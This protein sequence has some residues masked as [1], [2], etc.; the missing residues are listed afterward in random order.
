MNRPPLPFA[1]PC[2]EPH[3]LPHRWWTLPTATLKAL[4]RLMVWPSAMPVAQAGAAME[5][6]VLHHPSLVARAMAQGLRPWEWVRRFDDRG[7]L[8]PQGS[9]GPTTSLLYLLIVHGDA[10]SLSLALRNRMVLTGD[11]HQTW[12]S[13][14]LAVL[15]ASRHAAVGTLVGRLTP[16]QRWAREAALLRVLQDHRRDA[17]LPTTGEPVDQDDLMALLDHPDRRR[18]T[19]A[20]SEPL[21]V[22]AVR[23]DVSDG[24]LQA[25]RDHG[26]VTN[27]A[28]V[29]ALRELM[30]RGNPVQTER[31]L[32]WGLALSQGPGDDLAALD[33]INRTL[34]GPDEDEASCL[35]RE[36]A[37]LDTLACHGWVPGPRFRQEAVLAAARAGAPGA[38]LPALIA[39]GANPRAH[40]GDGNTALHRVFRPESHQ[41]LVQALLDLGVDPVHPNAQGDSPLARLR[42]AIDDLHRQGL[43]PSDDQQEVLASM[44]HAVRRHLWP[45]DGPELVPSRTPRRPRL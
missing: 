44:E 16:E 23:Q 21:L 37:M 28:Q 9:D 45:V 42:K 10:P 32:R 29:P 6:L 2:A 39:R 27:V 8:R 33:V 18:T 31:F 3:Q 30:A 15:T 38:L 43:A 4:L 13:L 26:L 25:L 24:V 5:A 19:L 35:R 7:Q 20:S 41:D 1:G 12:P 34:P 17:G 22:D 11:E 14:D 36:I 40:D